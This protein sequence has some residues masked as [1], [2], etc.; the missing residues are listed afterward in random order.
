V[1]STDRCVCGA[2]LPPGHLYA[3]CDRCMERMHR[4]PP[5]VH[6]FGRFLCWLGFHFWNFEPPPPARCA[7][8]GEL[9][10]R[11]EGPPL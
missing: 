8:C 9:F 10:T 3:V 1:E 7:R 11:D 2:A 4:D 6:W 5:A